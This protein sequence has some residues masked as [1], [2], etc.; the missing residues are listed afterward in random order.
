MGRERL[1]PAFGVAAHQT[2]L[3]DRG[4]LTRGMVVAQ[5]GGQP[6]RA[7]G[8]RRALVL[9]RLRRGAAPPAEAALRKPALPQEER[10]MLEILQR[11][12]AEGADT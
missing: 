11:T 3:R 2:T 5:A 6:L 7:A 4:P 8:L 9:E 1:E 12:R 10:D